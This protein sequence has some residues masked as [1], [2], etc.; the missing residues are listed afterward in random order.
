MI[1]AW[2]KEENELYT[3]RF[4]HKISLGSF[5]FFDRTEFWVNYAIATNWPSKSNRLWIWPK[6]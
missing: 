2:T 4:K 6:C 5:T 1:K 3:W